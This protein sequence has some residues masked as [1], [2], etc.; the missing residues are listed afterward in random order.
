MFIFSILA[1]SVPL[2]VLE[3]IFFTIFF[4]DIL[5]CVVSG[6]KISVVT[7]GSP[8]MISPPTFS[9]TSCQMPVLRSRIP[10]IQSHP[11]EEINVGP[12]VLS[13]P[14]FSPCPAIIDCS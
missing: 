14:P 11:I 3:V 10:G 12:S 13:T 1:V 6:S 4:I 9:L 5:A 7:R 8:I 2:T